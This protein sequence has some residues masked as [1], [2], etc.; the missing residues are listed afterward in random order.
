[1]DASSCP[2]CRER[3]ERIAALERRVK[4][5]EAQL[6][7]LLGRHAGNSSMPPSA[8]PPGAPKPVTK[9]P[10]GPKPGAQPGH[11]PPTPVRL[12]PELVTK[13]EHLIPKHCEQCQY[14]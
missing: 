12:P 9:E 13:T 1:M 8:N 6:R 5:L 11:S 4:E 2:G 3:D 14:V 10:T 7:Q